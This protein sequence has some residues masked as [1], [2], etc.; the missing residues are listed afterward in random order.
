MRMYDVIAHKRD[1]KELTEEEIT[2][3]LRGY[4]NGEIPDYQAS[5]LLM[6]AYLRGLTFGETKALTEAVIRSGA[7]LDWTGVAGTKADKHSTGGVGDGVSLA[8][9]PIVAACGVKVAMMSGRGLGHTG[10]TLDKL[11]AIE[12]YDCYLSQGRFKEVVDKV[13]CSIIGQTE[14]LA[15]ADK[16]LYAL[17]DVTATVDKKELITASILGKKLAEGI[18][19]LV[20]DV[21]VGSGAFMKTEREARELAELMVRIAKAH[22][23]K[24]TALLTDMDCPLGNAVG[25]SLEVVEAVECLQGRAPED[26]TLLTTELAARMLFL[27]GKGSLE[28]CRVECEKAVESGAA[29]RKFKEMVAAQGGNT[30]QIEDTSLFPKAKYSRI[31]RAE[32][33]GYISRVDTELY[34][35]ASVLLGAGRLKKEDVIDPTAGIRI[36][37]KTGDRAE[38]GD[39]IAVLFASDEA[40]F[41]PAQRVLSKS[42][43]YSSVPPEKRPLI[44]GAIE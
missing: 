18:D 7:T 42:I 1:G 23:K 16:K 28:E 12:G 5:A 33:S 4:T 10:G 9:A 27:A 20:L 17:R 19:C 43:V 24:V 11:E 3:F 25:N 35:T 22:G 2:F 39:G 13:G 15:P 41:E 8:V 6:A 21:K 31:V 30:A 36:L 38:A 14:A 37:K 32:T 29:F 26:Y 44:L 34:G 40:L